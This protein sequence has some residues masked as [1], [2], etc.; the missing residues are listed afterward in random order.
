MAAGAPWRRHEYFIAFDHGRSADAVVG[1]R[2]DRRLPQQLAC[3]RCQAGDGAEQFVA[4]EADLHVLANALDFTHSDGRIRRLVSPRLR[5][6]G[7]FTSL[8]I[9]TRTP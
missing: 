5:L 4:V 3:L 7:Q 2:E 8:F 9:E 1:A 6:P